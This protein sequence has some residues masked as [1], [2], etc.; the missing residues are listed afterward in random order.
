MNNFMN[1]LFGTVDKGLCRITMNGSIAVKTASGYKTYNIKTKKLTNV[2]NFC[3]DVGVEMFFVVPTNKVRIGDIILVNNKPKCVIEN[4]K[5][6]IKVINYED[7]TIDTIIPERHVFM[8][9]TYIYGKIV[10]MFGNISGKSP[11]NIFK[12]MLMSQMFNNPNTSDSSTAYHNITN[13]GNNPNPFANMSSLMPLML[14][15]GGNNMFDDMFDGMFDNS[16]DD[17][18]D[19]NNDDSDDFEE[20]DI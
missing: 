11:K 5:N 13:N 6:S 1:N 12:F 16:D 8:G 14:M 17:T 4:D 7:S 15:S 19:T 18:S 20:E 2:T 3:F 10:S 9:N